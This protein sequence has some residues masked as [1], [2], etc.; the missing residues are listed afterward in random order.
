VIGRVRERLRSRWSLWVAAIRRRVRSIPS[1]AVV[2]AVAGVVGAVSAVVAVSGVARLNR[3]S[4][5]ALEV[6]SEVGSGVD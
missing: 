3:R 4:A 2:L 6:P 5:P 1:W